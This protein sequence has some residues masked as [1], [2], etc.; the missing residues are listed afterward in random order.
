MKIIAGL[1]NPGREYENTKHNVGF[2]TLDLLSEMLNIPIRKI[3]FKGLYGEGF[4][5][6][7]KVILLKP[8]TYM[9]LSGECIREA[10]AFYK[11]DLEDLL[12]IYDDLDLPMGNLRIRKKGSAGTHNGMR[13]VVYQLGEDAFPR[14][15]VG[16]GSENRGDLV[17]YVI[18]GFRKEDRECMESAIQR[19]AEA[20]R[21]FVTEGIEETMAKYNTKKKK[22]KKQKSEEADQRDHGGE[23]GETAD[24]SAAASEGTHTGGGEQ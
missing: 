19:A 15:R 22:A 2:M 13:S 14:V 11:P 6:G 7:E 10:T 1:G 18:S 24:S 3:K 21:C 23:P 5:N 12:V 17:N 4:V 8:Q 20:A 16:I 9:N